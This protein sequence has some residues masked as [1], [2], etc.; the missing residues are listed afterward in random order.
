[1][2]EDPEN[3]GPDGIYRPY[4]PLIISGNPPKFVDSEHLTKGLR[5]SLI[6]DGFE[7]I[8]SSNELNEK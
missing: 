8:Q 4:I 6:N 2:I 5:E 7:M 1:M 3:I